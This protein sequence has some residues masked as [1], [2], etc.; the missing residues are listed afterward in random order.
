M[1]LL[2]DTKGKERNVGWYAE[3]MCITTKYLQSICRITVQATPTEIIDKV[4]VA[5][6]KAMLSNT[7]KSVKEIAAEMHFSSASSFHL[8]LYTLNQKNRPKKRFFL[9]ISKKKCIFA[10]K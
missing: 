3:Q 5:E 8:T 10:P 6:I 4:A 1:R 7:N 9:H 2:K